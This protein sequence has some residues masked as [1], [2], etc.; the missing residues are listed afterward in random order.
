MDWDDDY[1]RSGSALLDDS[2][3]T[4]R[5]GIVVV[6]AGFALALATSLVF[7]GFTPIILPRRL[8]SR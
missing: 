7:A 5:F 2:P 3:P 1:Q 4:G 8:F 6:G